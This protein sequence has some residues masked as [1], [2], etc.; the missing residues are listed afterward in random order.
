M[1][2]YF[3][4]SRCDLL[5]RAA[6]TAAI[7]Q[8]AFLITA[9]A[10]DTTR[11]SDNAIAF[12][13]GG[14]LKT[15]YDS[16]QRP[17]AV[18]L[19]DKLHIVFNAGGLPEDKPKAKTKSMAITYDPLTREF[20]KI[21]TLGRESSDHHD[22]PVIWADRENRLHVF[23]DWHN[24]LGKHL[25]SNEPYS[26]GTSLNDWIELP[27]P[28]QKMAY[29]WVCR[30]YNDKQLVFYR[31]AGHYSSWSYRITSDNGQTWEGPENDVIDLDI[32]GGEDTDWST[33]AAKVVSKDGSTLHVGFIAY[34]DCKRPRSSKELA[35]GKLDGKRQQ[36]PLYD[37]RK[38]AYKY[39]LY[40]VKVNLRTH[41]VMNSKGEII[42]T[43]IDLE[44]ANSKCM[45][46]DTKWRGTGIVPCIMVD[47]NDKAS[48]LHNLSDESHEESLGYHYV[49]LEHGEWKHTRITDSNHEWNSGYLAKSEDGALHAYVITGS[50]YLHSKGYMDKHGGGDIEEWTSADQGKT[51][52]KA[53]DLTPDGSKYAGWRFNNVQPVTRPDG[54]FVEGMLLFYGWK[55]CNAPTAQAFLLHEGPEVP[56]SE[57]SHA[58]GNRSPLQ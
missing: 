21:V 7:I 19:E 27:V 34:D 13:E 28:A 10:V 24:A 58:F 38:V 46:W 15:L 9:S 2:D 43:P 52:K 8:F 18:F 47:E 40:Y 53:R 31:T 49:R 12:G 35:S 22:G 33:Y 30:V 44:T 54:S 51:W 37:N 26:I 56:N 45:I 6:R 36:N 3:H 5:K 55:D 17:Q 29:P 48:F 42:Q 39:N 50:G 1:H 32:K 23:D 14:Q 25:I 11:A 20:S 16:R 4:F 41:Q 57:L